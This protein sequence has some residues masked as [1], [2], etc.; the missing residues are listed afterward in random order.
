[1]DVVFEVRAARPLGRS[2]SRTPETALRSPPTHRPNPLPPPQ[3]QRR[4]RH[5]RPYVWATRSGTN[6]LNTCHP[7]AQPGTR[8]L[9]TKTRKKSAPPA[10]PFQPLPSRPLFLYDSNERKPMPSFSSQFL[11][12]TLCVLM[13]LPPSF[14][15][16]QSTPPPAQSESPAAQKFAALSDQFMKDSLA[17]SPV[18]ASA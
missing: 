3:L 10:L 2:G 18:N 11:C 6:Q 12:G 17:L 15:S 7:E 8:F 1:M 9:R 13:T 4:H 16:R 14:S 5:R